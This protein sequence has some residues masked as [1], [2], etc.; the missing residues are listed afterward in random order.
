ML[1]L[2]S[3]QFEAM[4]QL[5]LAAALGGLVGIERE[6][7]GR[8]AGF[9]THLLVCLGSCLVM[10]ISLHFERIFGPRYAVRGPVSVDPA[11]LAYSV[12]SGIGFIGAGAIIKS[13]LAIR[14]LTTAASLWCIA[15]V[16]MACGFAMYAIAV[17]AAG[18]VLFSLFA[19][20][21]IEKRVEGHW[22]KVIRVTCDDRAGD[23]EPITKAIEQIGAC[24]LDVDFDHNV[25]DHTV[26]ITYGV[27]FRDRSLAP[28]IYRRLSSY[29]SLISVR[30][31]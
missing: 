4:G 22:Y 15:A 14:G 18:L 20:N 29:P 31:E 23:I 27:R 2:E 28:T 24:I 6:Y 10:L 3:W 8:A 5:V 19:L 25:R 11:R 30:V 26:T 13:G 17:F 16:G 7:H 1:A 9:R 21:V 12:M